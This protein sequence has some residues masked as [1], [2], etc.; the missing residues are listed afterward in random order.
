MT[1]K[2]KIKCYVVSHTHWDREWYLSFQEYRTRLVRVL[3]KA[4]ELLENNPN[5]KNFTL[6][7]QT[8]ALEDYLEVKPEDELRI[9]RLVAS[10]KLRIGPWFTQPDE[11]LV[12]AESLVRNLMV[13]HRIALNMGGVMKVGYLPDTFCHIPQLPQILRGFGIDNFVFMRGVGDEGEKLKTEFLYKGPDGSEIIAIHLI[14]SYCNA[15]MLGVMRP[16]SAYPWYSP[17]GWRTVHMRIYDEEPEPDLEVARD[18]VVDLVNRLKPMSVSGNILLMNGCDHMP[19]QSKLPDIISYLNEKE[20]SLRV[21]HSDI[22]RYLQ[23][24]RMHLSDFQT[25]E[26]ELRGAR[27]FPTLAGV[28]ST[29]IYLKQMNFQAQAELELYAEPISTIAH[30]TAGSTYPQ[31]LLLK[32]WKLLLLNQAHDS[33]YGSGVDQVH[34]ENES[35]FLSVIEGASNTALEAAMSIARL[36]S[37]PRDIS[38]AEVVVFNTLN[39]PRVGP[40]ST[41]VPLP[42]DRYVLHDG[43]SEVPVHVSEAPQ[44]ATSWGD[45][46]SLE[47]I[48]Q[49]PPLGYK[50]YSILKGKSPRYEEL[51][52]EENYVENSLVRVEADPERGGLLKIVEKSTGRVIEGL[53][54]F[55]DEGDAGDEYNFSPPSDHN[56]TFYSSDVRA[57][58]ETYNLGTRAVMKIALSMLVPLRVEGQ[59]RSAEMVEIPILSE[60]SVWPGLKRIDVKTEVENRAMD[61]RLRVAFPT[62]VVA[63]RSFA[64]Y[65]YQVIERDVEPRSKGEG[66]VEV[67]PT[68]HPQL[69]WVDVSDG[70]KG[71]MI[72]N[73]GMPEYELRRG[74]AGVTIYLTLIRAVG[75]LSRSDLTTRKGHAGPGLSTP[76]AQCLRRLTFEYSIIPHEG[77][78]LTSRTYLQGRG[79]AYP[80]LS[81][82]VDEPVGKLPCEMNFLKVEPE[83]LI[84]SALKRWE[85]GDGIVLRF[86]NVSDRVLTGVIKPSFSFSEAW[87]TNLNE[88]LTERVDI[89]DGGIR[90]TVKPHEIVT[91]LFK[92]PSKLF[93]EPLG[94]SKATRE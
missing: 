92:V 83:E 5:F 66:W 14:T 29:R 21:E 63:E 38:V 23:G 67:P 4:L 16:W 90:L 24:V 79:F 68:A 42:A 10:G 43:K 89:S 71:V 20:P 47:F 86:Y 44:E 41:V 50:V 76:G 35:R 53:N 58:V 22:E 82:V 13:G 19:P 57:K 80:P 77:T 78:W 18:R 55:V 91:L 72:A 8:S 73:K 88:E 59:R 94:L 31:R 33:I 46:C 28:Y 74:P 15:N 60:V 40:V 69:C 27:F 11:V 81:V 9:R 65:H 49:L 26:G 2:D 25:F 12:S 36:V 64:D 87:R 70:L 32:L 84:V 17:L 54:C 75:W 6:D 39:S 62:G 7:G 48:A 93:C 37:R 3:G 30:V 45:A 51:M 56:P 52:A 1:N 61:H 85:D 34:Q